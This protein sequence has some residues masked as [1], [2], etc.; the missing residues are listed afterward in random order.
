METETITLGLLGEWCRIF[1][2]KTRRC[3]S[4]NRSSCEDTS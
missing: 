4:W 3:V 1:F 2:N